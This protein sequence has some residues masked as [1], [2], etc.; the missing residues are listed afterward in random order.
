MTTQVNEAYIKSE[1]HQGIT[2]IEFFH[3]QSNSLPGHLLNEL[4]HSIKQAA[5]EPKTHVIVLRSRTHGPESEKLPQER[6][7]GR[8]VIESFCRGELLPHAS[9]RRNA[10]Q[11]G[12]HY[13]HGG[14][15]V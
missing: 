8:F 7:L 4:A 2:T 13:A 10:T 11:W 14:S 15:H 6:S 9:W 12:T 3:P 1:T 5:A